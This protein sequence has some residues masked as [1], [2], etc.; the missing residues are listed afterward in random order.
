MLRPTRGALRRHGGASIWWLTR[1]ATTIAGDSRVHPPGHKL[2]QDD[3]DR[4]GT[5]EA[6]A[7]YEGRAGTNAVRVE[8]SEAAALQSFP[9]DYPWQGTR[10]KRFEQIGNAVPPL[11]A[12]HLLAPFVAADTPAAAEPAA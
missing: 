11:L 3:R 2:N 9:A 12:A 5:A 6:E 4:L 7:R 10:S 1:P 8:E